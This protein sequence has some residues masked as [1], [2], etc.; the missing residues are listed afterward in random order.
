[1]LL[2]H[3]G[4]LRITIG[5]ISLG[6]FIPPHCIDRLPVAEQYHTATERKSASE[7]VL[8]GTNIL[9]IR[10]KDTSV[11][12]LEAPLRKLKQEEKVESMA[13]VLPVN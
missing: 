4:S 1:M 9:K 3:L 8:G 5:I 10:L 7:M 2:V 12:N 13:E 11:K 6:C